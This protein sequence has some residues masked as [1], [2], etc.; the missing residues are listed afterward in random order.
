MRTNPIRRTAMMQMRVAP[1]IKN[2]SEHIFHRIGLN[3]AEAIELFLRRVIVDQKLPFEVVALDPGTLTTIAEAWEIAHHAIQY[4][5]TTATSKNRA[6][7]ALS[8]RS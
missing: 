8:K 7:N 1:A 5:E 4:G 2:A 6:K 3:T